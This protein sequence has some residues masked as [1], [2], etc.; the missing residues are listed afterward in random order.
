MRRNKLKVILKGSIGQLFGEHHEVWARTPVEALRI[1]DLRSNGKF[2]K[3]FEGAA[4]RGEAFNVVYGGKNLEEPELFLAREATELYIVPSAEGEFF[5]I[6]VGGLLIAGGAAGIIGGAVVSQILIGIGTSLVIGGIQSLFAPSDSEEI[7]DSQSSVFNRTP[8]FIK[9]GQSVPILYG[10]KIIRSAPVISGYSETELFEGEPITDGV[11]K[12]TSKTTFY[13]LYL[14]SQGEIEG[15]AK[16]PK[17]SVLFNDESSEQIRDSELIPNP[18]LRSGL[19][20]QAPITES[21]G[22]GNAYKFNRSFVVIGTP[23][24]GRIARDILYGGGLGF[25]ISSKWDAFP[26][27]AVKLRFG[28]TLIRVEEDGDQRVYSLAFKVTIRDKDNNQ[29]VNDTVTVS[30]LAQDGFEF[31]NNNVAGMGDRYELN[32]N[33]PY[34]VKIEK[35]S[36]DAENVV[37]GSANDDDIREFFGGSI[38]GLKDSVRLVDELVLKSYTVEFNSGDLAKYNNYAVCAISVPAEVFGGNIPN[39]AFHLKGKKTR[40]FEQ[41]EEGLFTGRLNAEPDY[42][43][44]LTEPDNPARCTLDLLLNERYGLGRYIDPENIDFAAFYDAALY[45]DELTINGD[46]RFKLASYIRAREEVF[47]VLKNLGSNYRTRF[48]YSEGAI[49]PV[50]DKDRGDSTIDITEDI[51]K[52]EVDDDGKLSTPPFRYSSS[53]L[54]VRNNQIIV[55]FDDEEDLYLSRAEEVTDDSGSVERLG[56]NNK[57]IKAYGV[58]STLQAIRKGREVIRKELSQVYTCTFTVGAIGLLFYPGRIITIIDPLRNDTPLEYEIIGSTE[59]RQGIEWEIVSISYNRTTYAEIET[60]EGFVPPKLINPGL[61]VYDTFIWRWRAETS[62]TPIE[63]L[64]NRSI[65]I[66]TASIESIVNPAPNQTIAKDGDLV[67]VN[68]EA[69]TNIYAV[70]TKGIDFNKEI[71]EFQGDSNTVSLRITTAYQASNDKLAQEQIRIKN[72]SGEW[73]TYTDLTT[74]LFLSNRTPQINNINIVYNNP[75][76]TA[77]K[78]GDTVT[79][80]YSTVDVDI[81]SYNSSEL[82]DTV[83]NFNDITLQLTA[84]G[85]SRGYRES[86]HNITLVGRRESNNTEVE[87][88]LLVLIANDLASVSSVNNRFIR[89]RDGGPSDSIINVNTDQVV[90]LSINGTPSKG[91]VFSVTGSNKQWNIGISIDGADTSPDPITIPLRLVNNAS[92]ES[93]VDV[94]FFYQGFRQLTREINT[95]NTLRIEIPYNISNP[96][97]LIVISDSPPFTFTVVDSFSTSSDEIMIINDRIFE[98]NPRIRNFL[99]GS[100]GLMTVTIEELI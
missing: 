61:V 51:V 4:K 29:I 6:L 78:E 47:E 45:N 9:E 39:I 48:Y 46:R 98:F 5:G 10:E 75:N 30:A 79:I 58:V 7:D 74:D 16:S 60:G 89:A 31:S 66:I 42:E 91:N 99:T 27:L 56:I 3:Y 76:V 20:E 95:N 72:E 71:F 100:L 19:P 90:D 84:D 87:E 57:R 86:G 33:G 55:T 21:D 35:L 2:Q 73:S 70:E 92:I 1:I 80:T 37:D 23:S 22:L 34:K 88:R 67:N 18:I 85:I 59:V 28:S 53:E 36:V 40:D 68:V 8:E 12:T 82:S 17:E 94:E 41:D 44:G 43:M 64:I 52:Q 15:F 25:T 54:S 14:L 49:V 24:E 62:Q 11:G 83:I 32:G 69:D 93:L 26:N 63:T 81:F 38:S 77:L 65:N 13:L 50:Q 97:R 96:N